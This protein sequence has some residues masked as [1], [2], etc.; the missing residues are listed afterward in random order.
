LHGIISDE[1]IGKV[2]I[3]D[4]LAHNK[5]R[6]TKTAMEALID[7]ELTQKNFNCTKAIKKIFEDELSLAEMVCIVEN[8]L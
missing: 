8:N 4:A 5:G 6:I 7:L 1:E 2:D 3:M